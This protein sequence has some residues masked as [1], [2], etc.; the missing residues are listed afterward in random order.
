[1]PVL[2]SQADVLAGHHR[3]YRRAG[4]VA[5]LARA[6]YGVRSCRYVFGSMVPAVGLLRALPH[7]LGRRRSAED[8]HDAATR[9]VA[10]YGDVA[11]A[12]ERGLFAAEGRLR[13]VVDVPVGT[14]LLGVFVR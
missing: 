10:G 9:Q 7:R 8:E 14:S 6:G 12:F 1:M 3:R 13:R 2:W 5:D 11:R 4:L